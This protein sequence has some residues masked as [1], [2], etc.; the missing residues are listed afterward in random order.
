MPDAASDPERRAPVWPAALLCVAFAAIGAV[1]VSDARSY[2]WDE[3]MHAAL[4]AARMALALGSGAVGEAADV[5]LG[6]QQYPLVYPVALAAAEL[7]LGAGEGVARAFGRVVWGAGLLGLFLAA[8]EAV[9]VAGWPSDPVRARLGPYV[10]LALALLSPLAM[11][12]SGTL[13]QEAPF[14]ALAA[15]SVWAWLRRDGSARRELAAGA[16][17]ALAF[18]TR[19][20]TGLLLGFALFLDLVLQ[21][22]LAARAGETR[23]FAR[24]TAWLAA[25]P[26]LAFAWWFL[27]PLPGGAGLGAEHRAAF[28]AFL[29]GNRGEAFRIPWTYRWIDW[30]AGFA[31][32]PRAFV[33]MLAAVLATLAAVRRPGVRTLWILLLGAGVPV[34]AHEFHLDRF[35]LHQ[36]VA[37]WC[38]AGMG[39]ARFAPGP[40]P[41]LGALA[42]V[43]L[44]VLF[45]TV[46]ARALARALLRPAPDAEAYVLD[47]VD[48]KVDLSPG[49]RLETSGLLRAEADAILDL[50]AASA[51]P[52]ARVGW[53]GI[54][55]ELSP[56]AVHLGLLAR[57]GSVERF[58]RD[59][60]RAR[61]GGEPEMCVSFQG[62][63]PGWDAPRLAAWAERFDVV[64]TTRPADVKGRAT[65]AWV[66]GYQEMLLTTPGWNAER[67]GAVA[68]ARPNQEPVQVEVFA[69]RRG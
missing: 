25:I 57:G 62:A 63:D 49:R 55:S 39:I 28:V 10:A 30:A 36:G 20:N 53:L 2:G 5:A 12:Y 43:A 61:A 31:P 19:F 8:R 17:V 14:T 38:L 29:G 15:W 65:R 6:C 37:I 51:G 23:A 22:V 64:I 1:L 16:L 3:S 11:Q 27:L 48:R 67:L 54:S 42:L 44:A 52:D 18:F 13:F 50:V 7:V 9:R 66:A 40:S 68:V 26:A 4:P 47:A 34:W 46:D 45:P 58:R 32:S 24:R 56:A 41:A 60:G 35:L 59:A 33:L 69:C 21:G